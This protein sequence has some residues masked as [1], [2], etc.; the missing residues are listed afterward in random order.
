MAQLSIFTKASYNKT[1][2]SQLV[3]CCRC[4]E[5]VTSLAQCF[6]TFVTANIVQGMVKAM[7]VGFGLSKETKHMF[8]SQLLELKI[9]VN[10]YC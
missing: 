6:N 3:F 2:R 7:R 1:L 10:N 5:V 4:R 8:F 9:R